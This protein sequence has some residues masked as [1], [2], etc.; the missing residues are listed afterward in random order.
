M[1]KLDR[2]IGLYMVIRTKTR[3]DLPASS[4]SLVMCGDGS[5]EPFTK[6]ETSRTAQ[7][8]LHMRG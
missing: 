5:F 2:R 6:A 3:Q 8:R 1:R 7:V 4:G